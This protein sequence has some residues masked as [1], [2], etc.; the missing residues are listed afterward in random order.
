MS[1]RIPT[2]SRPESRLP[3]C[4]HCGD[5]HER[6]EYSQR[7]VDRELRFVCPTCRRPFRPTDRLSV[8]F[9]I[10]DILAMHRRG[11]HID[12]MAAALLRSDRGGR[13][14]VAITKHAERAVLL[15]ADSQSLVATRFD[16]HGVAASP[17]RTLTERVC[18][19]ESWLRTQ[20]Q[21]LVWTHPRYDEP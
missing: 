1:T 14:L 12:E 7:H 21:G 6:S 16:A 17:D 5:V 10:Y 8:F 2:F 11:V 15:T 9:E 20:Q 19:T 13:A 4:P 3:T 18:D